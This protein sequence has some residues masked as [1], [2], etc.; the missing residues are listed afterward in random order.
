MYN[1]EDYPMWVWMHISP[2]GC[3]LNSGVSYTKVQPS[4]NVFPLDQENKVWAKC[5]VWKINKEN[6]VQ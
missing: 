6:E 3:V 2:S 4:D 1:E 5:L